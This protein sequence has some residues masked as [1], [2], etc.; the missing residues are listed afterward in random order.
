MSE[1]NNNQIQGDDELIF[2]E[3]EQRTVTEEIN[4]WKLLIVD[5]DPEIHEITKM[6]LTGFT[7]QKR[8]I[9]FHHAYSGVEAKKVIADQPDLALIL[10]DVVMETDD[11]GLQLVHYIRDNIYNSYVRI[12]LRTGQPGQAPEREV[13]E[14]YDINDYKEKTELTAQK[15]VTTVISSLRS[16]MGILTIAK[17]NDELEEK[18]KERTAELEESLNIIKQ[19][20]E[21]GKK[22]QFKMLPENDIDLAPYHFTHNITPSLYLSGDFLDYFK[23]NSNYIGFYIADVSG[24]GASS[25]FVTILLKSFITNYLEKYESEDNGLIKSPARLLKKLNWTLVEENLDKHMTLFYGVI[26][27][28]ENKMTF[29]NGGQYP[30]PIIYDGSSST[31]MKYKGFPVG[32]LEFTQFE[33]HEL[34][35]PEEFLLLFLSDGVLEVLPEQD[36]E[37]QLDHMTHLID[38]FETSLDTIIN[39]IGFDE[40]GPQPDDLTFMMIKK[41]GSNGQ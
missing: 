34:D 19:D 3:D 5:D 24:H 39:K 13:I 21:A 32:L 41:G 14:N 23:I 12:I 10:L 38:N 22:V 15:L 4:P 33:Q 27:I 1:A 31:Y 37:K 7:F 29:A 2:F 11:S 40:T 28:R 36:F 8:G 16:Y 20:E 6:V 26:D 18:V 17:L 35:L 25:A 30:F 9:V